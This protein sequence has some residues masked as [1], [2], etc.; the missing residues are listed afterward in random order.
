MM[1]KLR[2]KK[3]FDKTHGHCHFCGDR[4]IFKHYGKTKRRHRKGAWEL[5]HVIQR[6]KGG[7]SSPDNY[8]P[9][10]GKCNHL[11]WH[12][13]GEDLRELILLGLVAKDEIKKKTDLGDDIRE[14]LNERRER[15]AKRKR[16]DETRDARRS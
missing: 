7:R 6:S 1:T 8:L 3:V 15:N 10:C 16:R 2:L 13:R 12:R 11:R 9:A 4:L 5:D 14:R